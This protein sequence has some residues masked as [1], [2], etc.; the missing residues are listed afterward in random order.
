[1]QYV[2]LILTNLDGVVMDEQDSRVQ[3]I[4]I[5][6]GKIVRVGKM[7]EIEA[8]RGSSTRL[9]DLRGRC[10]LPG[11][12]D[13]HVHFS[14]TGLL[15]AS[16]DLSSVRSFDGLFNLL[17]REIDRAGSRGVI[18]GMRIDETL[19]KERRLP[20]K[21]DLDKVAPENFL[22]LLHVTGHASIV[23][24]KTLQ[25]FA[26][27]P[28]MVGVDKDPRSGEPTGVLRA[29]ANYATYAKI[30]E[31]LDE[32]FL[33]K[34]IGMASE[35]ALR[36]G[37]TTIHALE[38][39]TWGERG[40][41]YL[42]EHSNELPIRILIYDQ[43]TNV[44]KVIEMGLTRIGGCLLADGA[45]E[46]HTGAMLEPYSDDPKNN[47]TLYFTQEAMNDFVLNAHRKGLQIAVHCEGDA[48]IEQV[49]SAYEN[50]LTA[51]PRNDH[52]HRIEHCEVPTAEQVCRIAKAGVALGMQPAFI[53][54][55]GQPGGKYE[56]LLG[57]GRLA[58]CH[59]Y[60]RLVDL[61][62][63]F[64]GGSDSFVTP[65]DP[66]LGIHALVNASF[67]NQRISV[68]EALK[69][70]TINA[71]R[72]AFEENAKGTIEAGKNAD[73]VVLSND[74]FKVEPSKIRDIKVLMT[75]VGG[76]L[77]YDTDQA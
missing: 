70:F 38:G 7:N 5:K 69:A 21:D 56:T 39:G 31:V 23:N 18:L 62:I 28:Q 64:A 3:A 20:T 8:L 42:R 63:L 40:L 65:I 72:I 55:W 53:H 10:V 61:G 66:I 17:R 14:L 4:A 73:L 74:P 25:S 46:T 24:S 32:R 11:F 57:K 35:T 6:N 15:L 2:D 30:D 41:H 22:W 12:I 48:A 54:H 75:I 71:A 36:A 51:F 43:T 47:G 77:A 45:F 34:M 16:L 44:S 49:L 52:R 67:E 27:P 26:F 60:R 68:K 37:V 1:M 50:A 19:M 9:L 76:N 59:P 29:D 13:T 58:R 33:G